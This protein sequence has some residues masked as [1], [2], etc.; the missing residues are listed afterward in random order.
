MNEQG[1]KPRISFGCTGKIHLSKYEKHETP[2]AKCIGDLDKLVKSHW[3]GVINMTCLHEQGITWRGKRIEMEGSKS[4]QERDRD[5]CDRR[6]PILLSGFC[7]FQSLVY[8]G[9]LMLNKARDG[10]KPWAAVLFSSWLS[11]SSLCYF[12]WS[13][14]AGWEK[15]GEGKFLTAKTPWL[16]HD[17]SKPPT[18]ILPASL[19]NSLPLHPHGADVTGITILIIQFS[20]NYF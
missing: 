14:V 20:V 4:L 7:N 3:K 19:S 18:V 10:T 8:G 6:N 16:H 2:R 17:C 5:I 1:N 11:L 15:V 12:Y 13:L 9:L